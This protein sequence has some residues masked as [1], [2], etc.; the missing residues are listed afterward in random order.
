MSKGALNF[1][2]QAVE[3]YTPK[4]LID[5]FGPFDYDPATTREQAMYH[6][7]H[8]YTTKENNGLITDWTAFKRIWINPPFNQKKE[9]WAKAVE[10][11][12]R[13]NNQIY[14]L[15]PTSFLTTKAFTTW[16]QPIHLYIPEGR[17]AFE[18]L[19]C[20]NGIAKS[21]AFGSVVIELCDIMGAGVDYIPTEVG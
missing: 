13:A 12:R 9:F 18:T 3:Y 2:E 4:K 5:Y 10:T 15:C 17:I 7:I 1:N 14:F 16:H 19:P 6:G 8:L 11:Y 20:G 21:P